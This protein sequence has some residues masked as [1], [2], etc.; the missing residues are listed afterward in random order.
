MEPKQFKIKTP[1]RP[2]GRT[3]L[4]N[5]AMVNYSMRLPVDFLAKAKVLAQGQP[6]RPF[7]RAIFEAGLKAM[8]ESQP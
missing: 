8:E 7:L 4:Y 1:E 5:E 3:P 2:F 6:E